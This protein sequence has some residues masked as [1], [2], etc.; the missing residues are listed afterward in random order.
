MFDT[1]TVIE[2]LAVGMLV[3]AIGGAVAAAVFGSGAAQR[4]RQRD[5]ERLVRMQR[6]LADAQGGTRR[7]LAPSGPEPRV[8]GGA[9]STSPLDVLAGATLDPP[10]SAAGGSFGVRP[11]PTLR[12]VDDEL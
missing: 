3:G 1:T 4:R 5:R 11:A 6:Y 10:T 8:V 12:L 9:N 7:T 2:A